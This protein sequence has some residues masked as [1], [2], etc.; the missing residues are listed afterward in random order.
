MVLITITIFTYLLFNIGSHSSDVG[1]QGV[2]C[3]WSAVK[4]KL[5]KVSSNSYRE[6]EFPKYVIMILDAVSFQKSFCVLARF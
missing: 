6:I 2:H 1:F 4:S 5:H 3:L